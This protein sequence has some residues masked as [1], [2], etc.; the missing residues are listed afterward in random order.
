MTY[1]KPELT[2]V[3]AAKGLVLGQGPETPWT[4]GVPDR[5]TDTE[6]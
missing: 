4:D 1:A 3:G 5:Y 6:P 2:L